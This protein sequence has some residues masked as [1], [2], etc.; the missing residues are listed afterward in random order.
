M[1]KERLSP[2]VGAGLN[3][4]FFYNEDAPGGAVTSIDY[5]NSFG[6]ALQAGVDYAVAD[7]WYVNFDVKKIFLST[8]VSINGGAINADV[9]LDPWLIG[10]GVGYRF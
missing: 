3:Y 10:V 2:Y 9:D 8:D 6:W 4:T 7:R 5:E 1:P